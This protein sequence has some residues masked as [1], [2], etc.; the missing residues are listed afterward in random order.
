MVSYLVDHVRAQGTLHH[1]LTQFISVNCLSP[2]FLWFLILVSFEPLFANLSFKAS[3]LSFFLSTLFKQYSCSPIM[4]THPGH[5]AFGDDPWI[6]K[7]VNFVAGILQ[8]QQQASDHTHLIRVVGVCFGHQIVGRTMGMPVQ[9][10]DIGW[11][12]S[13]LPVNLTDKGKEI[14]GKSEL[15]WAHLFPTGH[16]SVC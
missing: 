11:E 12:A 10:S 7:L 2:I 4:Y 8:R 1:S 16:H 14:F 9:R 5:S 6:I 15:V 3:L 13:V